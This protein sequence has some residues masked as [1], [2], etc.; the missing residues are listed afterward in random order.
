M[1]WRASK[2]PESKSSTSRIDE[3]MTIAEL[4]AEIR[5]NDQVLLDFYATWCGPCKKLKPELERLEKHYA[6]KLKI[7]RI[8]VDKQSKLA[9]ELGIVN[10]P[11]LVYYKSNAFQWKI[12]GFK[13]TQELITRIES[14]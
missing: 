2:L 5:L 6:G 9:E 4:E 7:I 8:D 3:E 1:A 14:K 13:T 10:I 11:T 12:L